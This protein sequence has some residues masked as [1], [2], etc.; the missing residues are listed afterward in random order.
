MISY[1]FLEIMFSTIK[2]I[3]SITQAFVVI[4]YAP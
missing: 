1:L 2:L 3:N 4:D